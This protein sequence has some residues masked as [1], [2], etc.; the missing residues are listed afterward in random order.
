M[1]LEAVINGRWEKVQK[2]N[3]LLNEQI[4]LLVPSVL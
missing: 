1:L 2:K 4:T 3:V